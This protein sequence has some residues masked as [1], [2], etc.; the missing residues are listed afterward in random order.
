MLMTYTRSTNYEEIEEI[1]Q[2]IQEL[3]LCRLQEKE[4]EG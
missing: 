1:K 2:I 4:A 3:E